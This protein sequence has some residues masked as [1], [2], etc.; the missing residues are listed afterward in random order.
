MGFKFL[1]AEFVD[2]PLKKIYLGQEHKQ[3]IKA[4]HQ[5]SY[6]YFIDSHIQVRCT[7]TA[8]QKQNSVSVRYNLHAPTSIMKDLK[9]QQNDTIYDRCQNFVSSIHA[10]DKHF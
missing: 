2:L 8:D 9:Q 4:I 6:E 7:L 10:R 5:L 1:G 3:A